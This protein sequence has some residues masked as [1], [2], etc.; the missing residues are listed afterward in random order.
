M[1][2]LQTD[3]FGTIK[4][5]KT[6]DQRDILYPERVISPNKK[7]G[8]SFLAAPVFGKVPET[9]AWRGVNL[10]QHGLIRPL[11]YDYPVVSDHSE[12]EMYQSFSID[13]PAR[14]SYPWSHQ[15]SHRIALER[16]P[17]LLLQQWLTITRVENCPTKRMM[18]LSFGLHPYFATYGEYWQ[19]FSQ[20]MAVC[21][22]DRH[23]DLR[24]SRQ[25]DVD[26]VGAVLYWQLSEYWT[27][28]IELRG[29]D[30][31][32]VWTDASNHYVC[33]EPTY[34]RRD[35]VLLARGQSVR[36]SCIMLLVNYAPPL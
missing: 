16:H 32:N 8:G 11:R 34:G 26:L 2:L 28:K 14:E 10:P 18:P 12:K 27:I 29:F 25:I 17:T 13:L 3:R 15:V 30:Q 5:W 36:A 21:A 20:G 33:I 6:P 31:V 7:R 35:E 24:K 1:N 9:V 22:G 4:N 19:L 23:T